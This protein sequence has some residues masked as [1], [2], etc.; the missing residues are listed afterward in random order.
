MKLED[1]VLRAGEELYFRRHRLP[2]VFVSFA[3]LSLLIAR[4][5]SIVPNTLLFTGFCILISFTGVA[6]RA[7]SFGFPAATGSFKTT[8]MYSL[9]RHPA[10]MGTFMAW[11]GAIL[12]VGI[13]WFVVGMVLLYAFALL[14]ILLAEER[15]LEGRYGEPYLLWT[16]RSSAVIPR[17]KSW[18][19]AETRFLWR[20]VLRKESRTLAL[21]ITMFLLIT[22]LKNRVIN[23]TWE[24]PSFTVITGLILLGTVFLIRLTVRKS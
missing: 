9:M 8:G 23:F 20:V 2:W 17:F 3:F 19:K 1:T 13:L 22:I 16:L 12:Y 11:F 5:F 10:A 24:I 18:R 6:V 15:R 7:L 21:L 14:L 4:P